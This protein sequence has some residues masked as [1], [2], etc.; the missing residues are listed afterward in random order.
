MVL[1]GK[2]N[3]LSFEDV[4]VEIVRKRMDCQSRRK[5]E[6]QGDE[7]HNYDYECYDDVLAPQDPG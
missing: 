1:E 4:P 3:D 6:G 5:E 2:L 7:G